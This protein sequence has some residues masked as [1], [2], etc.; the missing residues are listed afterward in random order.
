MDERTV[1]DEDAE[2]ARG[3]E[4]LGRRRGV[5]HYEGEPHGIV[6][7]IPSF[8]RHRDTD[9]G[10]FVDIGELEG[11]VLS[12]R[13]ASSGEGADIVGDLLLQ[14]ERKPSLVVPLT[15]LGD[16]RRRTG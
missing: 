8:S 2:A 10:G 9:S 13:P 14:V 1:A 12:L 11:F 16:I 15:H 5:V 4:T 6:W 7:P 3:E